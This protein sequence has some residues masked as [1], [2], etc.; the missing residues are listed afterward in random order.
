MRSSRARG[1]AG[2][3]ARGAER[4]PPRAGRRH[5]AP[6]RQGHGP[7][8]PAVQHARRRRVLVSGLGPQV[9]YGFI[10]AYL[11]DPRRPGA[12]P[13][14]STGA[15]PSSARAERGRL[16]VLPVASGLADAVARASHGA[17]GTG[18]WFAASTLKNSQWRVVLTAHEKT[19]FAPVS[20][21]GRWVP[22]LLFAAFGLVAKTVAVLARGAHPARRRGARQPGALRA[23]RRGSNDG[24]WDRDFVTGVAY[25]SHAGRPCSAM[26]PTRSTT[27]STVD[28]A[29]SRRRR[30]PDGG[31]RSAPARGR[32]LLR[33]RAP[34]APP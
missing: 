20:G 5:L 21:E 14:C 10:G 27:I 1:Q 19:L 29:A 33:E 2:V 9:L 18:R 12:A 34:H 26:P 3:R 17:F 7:V 22:W 13:T 4:Q 28:R 6:R 24:I 16:K 30:G 11:A 8:R 32:G 23:R 31:L 25:F 15:V